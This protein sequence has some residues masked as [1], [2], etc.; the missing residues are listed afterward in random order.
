MV[1]AGSDSY[2]SYN[3]ALLESIGQLQVPKRSSADGSVAINAVARYR[4]QLPD[5]CQ[6]RAPLE[7]GFVHIPL[8]S[9]IFQAG[10]FEVDSFQGSCTPSCLAYLA[11]SESCASMPEL[12]DTMRQICGGYDCSNLVAASCGPTASNVLVD[13]EKA[14]SGDCQAAL[15]APICE[16]VG[17]ILPAYELYRERLGPSGSECRQHACHTALSASC[18]GYDAAQ[19][20]MRWSELCD[21]TCHGAAMQEDCLEA[22]VILTD[23]AG[24]PVATW[25]QF[26]QLPGLFGPDSEGCLGVVPGE[27]LPPLALPPVP[28]DPKQTLRFDTTFPDLSL[29]DVTV[30]GSTAAFRSEVEASV[31]SML[32][33]LPGG[34]EVAQVRV[35][36]PR[37]GSVVVPIEVELAAG[38]LPG[39]LL[40]TLTEP[41][42]SCG[43][44]DAAFGKA[45][46]PV[47]FSGLAGAA[48]T[49]QPLSIIDCSAFVA[50]PTPAAPP[51]PIA[52]DG[53]VPTPVNENSLGSVPPPE[54]PSPGSSTTIW[55]IVVTV[56]ALLILAAVLA[57]TLM[58]LHRRRQQGSSKG[59]AAA[60]DDLEASA[61]PA[62]AKGTTEA[63][64]ATGQLT[65][66]RVGPS[67]HVDLLSASEDEETPRAVTGSA[68]APP[69]ERPKPL[70][71][72][73]LLDMSS[74]NTVFRTAR[75]EATSE[76]ATTYR[77]ACEASEPPS[78]FRSEADSLSELG[79]D[80]SRS[81]LGVA[82]A[83]LAAAHAVYRPAMTARPDANDLAGTEA[84]PVAAAAPA[85]GAGPLRNSAR[86]VKPY[87]PSSLRGATSSLA[88][89]AAVQPAPGAPPQPPAAQPL[90]DT[91][92]LG[93][94]GRGWWGSTPSSAGAAGVSASAVSR[95]AARAPPDSHMFDVA[96]PPMSPSK[97]TYQVE[98]GDGTGSPVPLRHLYKSGGN[99]E[100]LPPELRQLVASAGVQ[101]RVLSPEELEEAAAMQ[102][103]PDSSSSS[104]QSYQSADPLTAAY[105][106]SG[107]S[108]HSGASTARRSMLSARDSSMDM[109]EF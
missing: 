1:S 54:D 9:I 5:Q 10:V 40:D 67:H 64:L 37:A 60:E 43:A 99:K 97:V 22:D 41:A 81:G 30:N 100:A 80:T 15:D 105:G 89:A 79:G 53:G 33:A 18:V 50:P 29:E 48:P 86:A 14:C 39:P 26:A 56:V 70:S 27:P 24:E 57:G 28:L 101:Q 68:N 13:H 58:Y 52:V 62:S 36:D 109:D 4:G 69:G 84:A 47:L 45:R 87:M 35:G 3:D 94:V 8:G 12:R 77:T 74:L 98:T 108:F 71:P 6:T 42:S 25:A 93:L 59:A 83:G 92:F 95:P 38:S 73:P 31:R 2:R 90:A 55:A 7:C 11:E 44:A 76:P 32:S 17:S 51:P 72:V 88:A 20:S 107:D 78:T 91:G 75:E 46:G 106:T 102:I 82:A 66:G 63:L 96:S 61:L 49:G 85:A 21:A 104:G 65:G 103:E 19:L 34:F 16:G 23:T